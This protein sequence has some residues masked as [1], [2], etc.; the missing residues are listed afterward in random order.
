MAER[1]RTKGQTTMY[2]HYTKG[3][4]NTKPIK[5]WSELRLIV[6][7]PH[8]TPVVLLLNDTTIIIDHTKKQQNM[9]CDE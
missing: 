4:S 9:T 2:K 6:P 7:S 1:K 5:N 3:S 8:V